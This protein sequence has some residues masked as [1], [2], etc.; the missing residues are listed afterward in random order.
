VH[1]SKDR[2]LDKVAQYWKEGE[3]VSWEP[4]FIGVDAFRVPLPTYPF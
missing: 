2:N 1:L 3:S 4:L